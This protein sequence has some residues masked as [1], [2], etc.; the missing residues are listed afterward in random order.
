M[1][2]SHEVGGSIPP[3]S[4]LRPALRVLRVTGQ[5]RPALRVLRVTGQLRSALRVLRVAGH[6]YL[7]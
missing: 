5:L 3:G 4:T 6:T 7:D 2:G 1:T